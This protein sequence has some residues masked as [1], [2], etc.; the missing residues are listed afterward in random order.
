MD[1]GTKAPTEPSNEQIALDL[2]VAIL[3]GS[4]GVIP[5]DRKKAAKLALDWYQ[6]VLA[7]TK[8]RLK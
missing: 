5:P 8:Q 3:A 2:T 6:E 7:Q 1:A 4:K